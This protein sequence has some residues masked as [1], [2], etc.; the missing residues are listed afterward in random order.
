[1]K[2]LPWINYLIQFVTVVLGI[3]LAFG[4][5]AY[6]NNSVEEEEKAFSKRIRQ[7]WIPIF[8]DFIDNEQRLS[9]LYKEA[10]EMY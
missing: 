4:L 2:N 9:I 8:E 6:Y 3:L 7:D 10:L 5:N 1:M